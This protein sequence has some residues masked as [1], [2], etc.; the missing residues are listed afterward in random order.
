MREGDERRNVLAHR[1]EDLGDD[2][3]QI[4]GQ[5]LVGVGAEEQ[6]DQEDAADD[7]HARAGA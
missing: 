6:H 3:A 2:L 7:R 4:A 1:G 5:Q